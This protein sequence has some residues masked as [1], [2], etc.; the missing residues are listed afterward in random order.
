MPCLTDA[1]AALADVA[2]CHGALLRDRQLPCG[3]VLETSQRS[4]LP[5]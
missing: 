1:V 3:L 2:L 4:P 5:V